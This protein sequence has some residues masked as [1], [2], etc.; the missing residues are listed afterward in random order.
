MGE[1]FLGAGL[2]FT[3]EAPLVKVNLV[4]QVEKKKLDI[5]YEKQ[6]TEKNMHFHC[7]YFI[8]S[9]LKTCR[10][11]KRALLTDSPICPEKQRVPFS[12]GSLVWDGVLELHSPSMWRPRKAQGSPPPLHNLRWRAT[13]FNSW[14]ESSLLAVLALDNVP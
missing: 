2:N 1:G 13:S 8:P 6:T 12:P 4:A 10:R 3:K 5:N 7:S 9:C 14:E 11:Q